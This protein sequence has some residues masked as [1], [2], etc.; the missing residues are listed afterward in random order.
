MFARREGSSQLSSGGIGCRSVGDVPDGS[1][2]LGCLCPT[3]RRIHG[4]LAI[5]KLLELDVRLSSDK[6]LSLDIKCH[7][8]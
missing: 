8:E 1:V 4:L 3:P 5:P 6:V 7:S 2:R